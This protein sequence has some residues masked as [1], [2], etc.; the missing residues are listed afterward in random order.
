MEKFDSL[1][2]QK[3]EIKNK[4]KEFNFK[5]KRLDS[6]EDFN[7][8]INSFLFSLIKTKLSP[9]Y[10][11]SFNNFT[12]KIFNNSISYSIPIISI[13]FSLDE[14]KPNPQ[15]FSHNTF[16]VKLDS[17]S[18]NDKEYNDLILTGD[19]I[20]IFLKKDL[21]IYNKIQ[22]E[23]TL[24]IKNIFG[25]KKYVD[26]FF[27]KHNQIEYKQNLLIQNKIKKILLS[28]K[29]FNIEISNP[30]YRLLSTPNIFDPLYIKLESNS[31]NSYEILAASKEKGNDNK[32]LVYKFET[33][34]LESWIF[35]S[36]LH[37]EPAVFRYVFTL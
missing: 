25:H 2:S 13:E 12:F 36:L 23:K 22:K 18:F 37:K 34:D 33:K 3:K 5:Q 31:N 14:K 35:F 7:Q 17:K 28:G 20:K 15:D 9:L 6:I 1:E 11:S 10:T 24:L 8:I 16:K 27:K 26:K 19:I 21:K 4:V 32:P 30:T 29:I